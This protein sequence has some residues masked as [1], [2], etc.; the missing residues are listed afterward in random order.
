MKK[1]T[2]IEVKREGTKTP[3]QLGNRSES[4]R[5]NIYAHTN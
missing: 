4:D 3:K 5:K 2:K 1:M